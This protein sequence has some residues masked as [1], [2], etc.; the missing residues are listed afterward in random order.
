MNALFALAIGTVTL[1]APSISWAQNGNMMGGGMWSDGWMGA[2]G[3]MW[4]P[5]LLVIVVVG[6]VAWI[7]NRNGK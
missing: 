3:W 5:I 1:L 4:M 6:L 2:Y 7:V